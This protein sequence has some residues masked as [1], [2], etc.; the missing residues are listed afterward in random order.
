MDTLILIVLG[1]LVAAV[2]YGT[3][4]KTQWGINI[5][6]PKTCP[7]CGADLPKTP[8]RPASV[9]EALWGGNTCRN[10]GTRVDK[11]GRQIGGGESRLAG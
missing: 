11:W 6:P 7:V 9:T 1:F 5:R 2:I 10:G 8:R 4:A 3:V